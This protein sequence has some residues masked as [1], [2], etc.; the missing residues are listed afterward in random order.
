MII[1]YDI[2]FIKLKNHKK[3]ED[4]TCCFCYEKQCPT[5]KKGFFICCKKKEMYWSEI[6]LTKFIRQ[7]FHLGKLYV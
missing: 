4:C 1:K 5:D 2:F 3:D 7:K 6:L